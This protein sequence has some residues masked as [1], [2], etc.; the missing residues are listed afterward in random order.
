MKLARFTHHGTTRLGAVL[1]DEVV[2]LSVAARRLP[3]DILGLLAEGE[4]ALAAAAIGAD[5]ASER[6]PLA[7][8]RLE[9]PVPEPPKFLAIGINYAD[10][11][12]ETGRERPEHPIF[13]NKQRTCVTGPFDAIR[14]PPTSDQVDFEGEL[15]MVVGQR[16]RDVP[17]ERA[18][19]V[20]A[21]YLVV[22]DVSVRDWQHRAPTW[23]LGK[24]YD[25]H[26]PIG[27]WI[28]T[29]DE[30]PDPQ[31]LRLRT[32]VSGELMQDASTADMVFNCAEQIAILSAAFTLEPGD[33]ISTG[34]PGGV[35]YTRE[36]PRYLRG[37]DT[38]R[39][40][41]DGVGAIENAVTAPT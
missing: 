22:N 11:I 32:W 41:I 20:V 4:P 30:V 25:T 15:G 1:G 38:V 16:C 36:P 33:I 28:V 10:H 2:D 14:L 7:S 26:G 9:A 6:I 8:V 31:A 3:T 21:G 17:V 27:P 18:L 35:G 19:D 23:T 12:E 37:G 34:T 5:A 24:S 39:V 29:A 40:S 13:F